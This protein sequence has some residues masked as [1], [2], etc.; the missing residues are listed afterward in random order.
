MKL[1]V[2]ALI[3]RPEFALGGGVN[4][5][6]KFANGIGIYGI[7]P[8]TV[9]EGVHSTISSISSRSMTLNLL[10]SEISIGILTFPD[11]SISI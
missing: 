6:P 3:P 7:I 9:I 2:V 8:M 5:I 10:D 11:I 1:G 4:S